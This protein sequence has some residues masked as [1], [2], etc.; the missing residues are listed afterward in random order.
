MST[1]PLSCPLCGGQGVSHYH[2]DRRRDYW[3]CHR[4]TLVFVARHQHLAA[5]AEKAV[6][7]CHRNS[8]RDT[9]YRRFL[10]RLT[11]PLLEHLP[12]G[13]RGLDFGCGPGPTLSV[14]L[15]EAGHPMALYDI[16]YAPDR[17]VLEGRY[18]FIT[19]TEVVEHLAAP[20]QVIEDLAGRLSPGGWLGLMTKRV[21]SREAF[22]DW[23]YILDPTHVSFFS[24]ASFRWL[25]TCLDMR[26]VFPAADVVLMQKQ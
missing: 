15:E 13:A 24:E 7:D 22:A 16:F 14:M 23:H 17:R 3:Q 21:A 19:A 18:D 11:V 10:S 9:G 20:G 25:A 8:P 4:C 6:Y 1:T 5:D 2:R 26:V 12:P